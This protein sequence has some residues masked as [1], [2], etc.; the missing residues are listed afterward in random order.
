MDFVPGGELFHLVS[1]RK[2]LPEAEA[3]CYF[4]QAVE[5][6]HFAHGAGIAHRDLKLENILLD[7]CPHPWEPPAR[8]R[9]ADWGCSKDMV[10]S[11]AG[12]T[13]VGTCAYVAPEVL[14]TAHSGETYDG[15]AAD[16]WSLGVVLYTMLTGCYPFQDPPRREHASGGE[17]DPKARAADEKMAMVRNIAE[18]RFLVH[19]ARLVF[20]SAGVRELLLG[21]LAPIEGRMTLDDVRAHPTCHAAHRAFEASTAA[22]G[23]GAGGGGSD[24][25]SSD[26]KGGVSRLRRWWSK[27]R[28]RGGSRGGS[29]GRR[30][31]GEEV[32]M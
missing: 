25:D 14:R 2:R 29:P 32:R 27:R 4:A 7:R 15:A 18:L 11:L 20:V 16:V 21:M 23:A 26:E 12:R 22:A 9:I 28:E 6:L 10:Q 17:S 13:M 31:N 5:A 8:V 3:M 30:N 1:A 24:V 19:P